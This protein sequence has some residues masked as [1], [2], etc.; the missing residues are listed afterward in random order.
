MKCSYVHTGDD[1]QV[2]NYRHTLWSNSS[3]WHRGSVHL[4][5][6]PFA[7]IFT[8]PSL[9]LMGVKWNINGLFNPDLSTSCHWKRIV[10]FYRDT[11]SSFNTHGLFQYYM[12]YLSL[13]RCI[14][15]NAINF[16]VLH[17]IVY[18]I[19]NRLEATDSYFEFVVCFQSARCLEKSDLAA[20]WFQDF[21]TTQKVGVASSLITA[22]VEETRT[23]S[24][25]GRNVLMIVPNPFVFY[26]LQ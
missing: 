19:M 14:K 23:T 6:Y 10:A 4:T 11:S 1:F 2:T 7:V 3:L 22:V 25:L 21:F 26:G 13:T 5:S 8:C 20:R 12:H 15:A 16:C 24:R 9:I 17:V 18:C